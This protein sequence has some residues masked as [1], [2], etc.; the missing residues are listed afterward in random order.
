MKIGKAMG[1]NVITIEAWKCPGEIGWVWLI[2]YSIRYLEQEK[3]QKNGE[4]LIYK[5]KGDM[6]SCTNYH[7]IKLLSHIVKLWERVMA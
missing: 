5:N 2:G 7:G 6:Q 3:L 4:V 1:L